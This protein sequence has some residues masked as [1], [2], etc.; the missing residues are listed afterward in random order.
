[1][2]ATNQNFPFRGGNGYVLLTG[3]SSGI[4]RKTAITLAKRYPLIL[5]G[6]DEARL[7]ETA[8]ECMSQGGT[9]VTWA[10]D[11]ADIDGI[12]ASLTD[13]HSE[14]A[15]ERVY[16]FV[17]SAGMA[18]I[19]PLRM[20]D[21]AKMQQIMSVNFYSAVELI[22]QLLPRGLRRAVLIS[23]IQSVRGAKGQGI[24]CASKGAIDAFV[25]EMAL[26][27]PE[28]S[29]NS[30]LP[31]AIPSRMGK[32]LEENAALLAHSVDDGYILGLG[33]PG[34]IADMAEYLLS[35]K[36]AGISGQHFSVDGG[37]TSH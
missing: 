13:V 25:E 27:E 36:A 37:K 26:E 16:G 2:T 9:A 19:A 10:Y 31:G 20:L 3:A 22:Q 6:R 24:Y 12:A 33:E 4:G 35:E 17:H 28:L 34:S 18:P 30:I 32:E 15:I 14:N 21:T 29:I 7:A 1:M 23:S 11:L 8:S 5:C